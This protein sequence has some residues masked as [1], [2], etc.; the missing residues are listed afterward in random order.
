MSHLPEQLALSFNDFSS[1][2]PSNY[3]QLTHLTYL[4][5]ASNNFIGSIPP[6]ADTVSF[7]YLNDNNLTGPLPVRL[8]ASS[9]EVW[10]NSNALTGSIPGDF[11]V[12][13]D[14]LTSLLI[15]G[16][17][18]SGPLPS[19]LCRQT[20]L[21]ELKSGCNTSCLSCEQK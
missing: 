4:N 5:L 14:N 3:S 19:D 6:F 13:L 15:Y 16:N 7:L 18:L 11:G 2:I 1:T 17:H 21:V 9:T 10:L 20:N 12:D 8:P